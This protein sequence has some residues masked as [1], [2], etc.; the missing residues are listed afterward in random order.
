MDI[1]LIFPPL[2]GVD[3]PPLGLAYIAAQLIKY[4]HKVKV[5]C[6]NSELY[7][8][9]NNKKPLW[10]WDKTDE[11]ATLDKINSHF[12]VK[13]LIEKWAQEVLNSNPRIVGIS[14][15]NFS[16]ILA[17][18]LADKIKEKSN[19]VCMVFGGPWCTEV[20]ENNQLNKNVDI[21]VRGEGEAIITAIAGRIANNESWR[22]FD[23]KGTIVNTGFGFKDNGW[24][25]ASLD[26]NSIPSPA[27]G[28][29]DF[30]RYTN[31]DEIP[32]IFSR[33][34]NYNCK[35]C[36]DKPIW[37]NHRMRSAENIVCEMVK[38][39]EM[40][41]RK[42]FKCND[43]MI[44]G[45]LGGLD[46]LCGLIIKDNLSFEWGS[47]ARAR[48]DM[49]QEMFYRL[50]KAGCIYL[51]YG[52]ESGAAK[53]LYHMGKP[54]KKTIAQSLKRT[55]AAKI[56]VNTLWMAGYPVESWMDI[57][58]TMFFLIFNRKNI[59]EFVSVSPCYIP[60]KSWLGKQQDALKIKYND[61]SEWYIGNSNTPYIRQLRRKC[62]MFLARSLGLYRGGIK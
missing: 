1:A 34:C 39:S 18:L 43:L 41:K 30:N 37:G 46:D 16:M 14:T 53:V 49:S 8:Q 35:F 22:D 27:L 60:K 58:E 11:W 54:A 20:L 28:L 12:D 17:N 3:M 9:D 56:K 15:N 47:M 19:N 5:F 52:I 23:I 25:D 31:K 42:R 10:D 51:T 59:D 38:H 21:Y 62:L 32:I 48:P 7:N 6:F 57:A 29:F 26:I 33:G 4:G 24:N 45:D 2:Y 50:R 44:N 40:F 55:H 61:K 36:T 13:V